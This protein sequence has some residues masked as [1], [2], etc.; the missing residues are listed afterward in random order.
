LAA[1]VLHDSLSNVR[2]RMHDQRRLCAGF[3]RVAAMLAG[4]ISMTAM[5]R[6]G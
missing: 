1:S 6:I 3:R 4:A 5:R 2:I